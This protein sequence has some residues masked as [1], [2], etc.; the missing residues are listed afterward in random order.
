MGSLIQ[1]KQRNGTLTLDGESFEHQASAVTMTTS[2]ADSGEKKEYLSGDVSAA[3]KTA[4]HVLKI[5]AAQDFTSPEGLQQFLA[6]HELQVVP[7]EWQPAGAG[8]PKRSGNVQI[9]LGD[10]GGDINARLET[11]IDLP[12]VGPLVRTPAVRFLAPGAT[13]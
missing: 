9:Q 5:K 2:Y 6:D 13:S 3:E 1:S 7:F 12:V 4:D 8:G 10:E 11:E